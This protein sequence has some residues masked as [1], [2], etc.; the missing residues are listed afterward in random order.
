M[1]SVAIL[2][3]LYNGASHLEAQLKSFTNQTLEDWTLMVGDDGSTDA[4]PEIVREFAR[5]HSVVLMQGPAKGSARNFLH[6]IEAAG[7]SVPYL[8]LSDQDDVWLAHKLARGVATLRESVGPHLYCS[9]TRIVGPDLQDRGLSPVWVK[10]FG[11]RNALVQNVAAGNT[12]ILNRAAIDL[13]QTAIA[14][15]RAA[16]IE[17][18]VV[19]DWWL[20]QLISG[21]GGVVLHD[22]EPTLLY[23][24]HAGNLIGDNRGIRAKLRRLAMVAGGTFRSWN[25]RNIA[26]L[27]AAGDLLTTQSRADL[28]RFAEIRQASL[29]ARLRGLWQLGLYRQTA[30]GQATL[31]FSALIGR[32]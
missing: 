18:V 17:D 11:F 26:A 15:M 16:L 29:A 7:D 10:P 12:I 20:Y 13:A 25:G 31:W 9:R 2:L 32:I 3:A 24:Q 27:R 6:L 22:H 14:R 8:A 5:H 28:E 23:R 30:A 4:G 21:A 19:H 1:T